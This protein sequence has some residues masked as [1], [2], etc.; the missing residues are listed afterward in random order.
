MALNGFGF[1]IISS[2]KWNCMRHISK[3]IMSRTEECR[4]FSLA[5]HEKFLFQEKQLVAC[6]NCIRQLKWTRILHG[7]I[8]GQSRTSWWIYRNIAGLALLK[9]WKE[10]NYQPVSAHSCN[11]CYNL[12]LS[13]WWM[14]PLNNSYRYNPFIY[15]R[16]YT[17]HAYVEIGC[18]SFKSIPIQFK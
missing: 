4:F 10:D 3:V 5:T 1:L 14:T 9:V 13:S 11:A 16:I 18:I 2:M 8:R 17:S 7:K 6:Y 12:I 15:H